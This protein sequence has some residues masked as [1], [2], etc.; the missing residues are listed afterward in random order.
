MK[1]NRNLYRSFN[2][3]TVKRFCLKRML[4]AML[5]MLCAAF[6]PVVASA[7]TTDLMQAGPDEIA[8]ALG[9]GE[10]LVSALRR[11]KVD[12][13]SANRA[14]KSLGEVF[15][16]R[17][18]RSND[19]YV[20]KM[21]GAKKLTLLRYQRNQHIYET[22]LTDEGTYESRLLD[23]A[24]L[25]PSREVIIE[26]P[27]TE[28]APNAASPDNMP[29]AHPD[30]DT[31]DEPIPDLP[32]QL[33]AD[34]V[35]QD[36]D[37]APPDAPPQP[38][39]AALVGRISPD[40][41]PPVPRA[42]DTDEEDPELPGPP[43]AEQQANA[44]EQLLPSPA[45]PNRLDDNVRPSALDTPKPS[46]TPSKYADVPST[47]YEPRIIPLP[48]TH[49]ARPEAAH[50]YSPY[51]LALACLGLIALIA[52]IVITVLPAWRARQHLTRAGLT[53]EDEIY[54]ADGQRLAV[55]SDSKHHYLVAVSAKNVQLLTCCDDDET[56]LR[57]WAF[58][59]RKTYWQQLAG[60]PMNEHQLANLIQKFNETE[61]SSD[62]PDEMETPATQ[63]T[64]ANAFKPRVIQS[65][66][67]TLPAG[68]MSHIADDRNA[69]ATDD[70]ET[71]EVP[72]MSDLWD[73]K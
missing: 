28:T 57:A 1:T 13:A 54:I 46:T 67:P 11:E 62:L 65:T 45:S 43:L 63:P 53:I 9:R 31:A 23:D 38:V 18:C 41:L 47:Q 32:P 48:T 4:T 3:H 73:K 36:E 19:R 52:G 26:P 8:G 15:P 10:L 29:S 50:G 64:P 61:G 12:A 17:L 33:G 69:G 2:G 16:M 71:L 55:V 70:L 5:V 40:E 39:D 30:Q 35:R 24:S 7:Q 56:A 66:T 21:N 22:I 25:Q 51:S 72:E 27:T 60:R 58:F 34:D 49:P 59:K 44:D 6:V 20:I 68:M 37:F 42:S 14:V